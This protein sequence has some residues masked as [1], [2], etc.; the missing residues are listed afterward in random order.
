MQNEF[1]IVNRISEDQDVTRWQMVATATI[2]DNDSDDSYDHNDD[3]DDSG[4]FWMLLSSRSGQL[5]SGSLSRGMTA[6]RR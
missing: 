6:R 5:Q 4:L 2:V 3:N 1:R